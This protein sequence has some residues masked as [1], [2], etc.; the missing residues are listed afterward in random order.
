MLSGVIEEQAFP[1]QLICMGKVSCGRAGK[2]ASIT[3]QGAALGHA[4]GA[5]GQ[6]SEA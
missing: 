3:R 5:H 1:I 2:A 6:A 4:A